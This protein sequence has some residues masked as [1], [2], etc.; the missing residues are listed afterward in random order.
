MIPKQC[1]KCG[2]VGKL[3]RSKP[4]LC[5]NCAMKADM[6]LAPKKTRQPI[7]KKPVDKEKLGERNEYYKR[8]IFANMKRNGGICRCDECGHE[9]RY[10]TGRNVA[11]IVGSGANET[12]YLIPENNFILGKGEMF[13]ECNCLSVFDDQG[14]KHTMKIYPIYVERHERLIASYYIKD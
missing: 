12:L 5:K 14:K 2:Y 8:A 10:P 9:I 6:M 13:R 11:H 4:P 7:K 3:W 1:S